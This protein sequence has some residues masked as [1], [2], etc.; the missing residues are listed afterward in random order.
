MNQVKWTIYRPYISLSFRSTIKQQVNNEFEPLRLNRPQLCGH[1]G[2]PYAEPENTLDAFRAAAAAG[3]DAVELDV[4]LLKDNSLIVFH[5]DG[6][7]KKPGMLTTYCGL[8]KSI[9]DYSLEE[10]RNLRL[11]PACKELPCCPE[12]IV[13]ASIPT[14][15][16]VLL[17]LKELGLFVK[18]ELKGEG[19]EIPCLQLVEKLD[20]VHQCSFASFRHERVARIRK[21][22]PQTKPDGTHVYVTGCLYNNSIPN[23]FV[24]LAKSIGATEIHLKYDTCTKE[25]VDLIHEAGM[26]SMAWFRGPKGMKEDTTHKYLDVGNEDETMYKTVINTGVMSLCVNKADVVAKIIGKSIATQC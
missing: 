4:F 19:T 21:E 5:G 12:K 26:R 13:K 22:R 11:S 23:N 24:D 20:M 3:C 17:L 15:E 6:S 18:I 2:F 25:R 14:L 7:D 16:E 9:L 10:V 1:R 8:N